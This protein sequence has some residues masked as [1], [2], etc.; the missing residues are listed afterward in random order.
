MASKTENFYK[1]EKVAWDV[2]KP[3][4][5]SESGNIT[6]DGDRVINVELLKDTDWIWT[7]IPSEIRVGHIGF[8]DGYK[9]SSS[10]LDTPLS[11]RNCRHKLSKIDFRSVA[12]PFEAPILFTEG[13][14]RLE[15]YSD[16]LETFN[17]ETGR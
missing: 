17:L 2:S 3:G 4:Y 6:L 1:T 16:F 9:P 5:V 8:A 14:T 10:T 11:V 12:Q 15:V 13:L 7:N